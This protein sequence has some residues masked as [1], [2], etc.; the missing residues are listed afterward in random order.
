[1]VVVLVLG[2][3][4]LEKVLSLFSYV[5]IKFY[6]FLKDFYLFIILLGYYIFSNLGMV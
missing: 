1:M 6:F 2:M 4:K 5:F 3:R